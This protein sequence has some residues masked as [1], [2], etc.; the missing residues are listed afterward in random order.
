MAVEGIGNLVQ[1]LADHLFGQAP[2]A[3]A[4]TRIPGAPAATTS[5]ATEDTFTPSDQNLSILGAAQAA[6]IFQLSPGA[7]TAVAPGTLST[8]AAPN[9]EQVAPAQNESAPGPDAN[10]AP[11]PEA[12]AAP[13]RTDA[14]S[15][16]AAG[17]GPAGPAASAEMQNKI[18]QLN[19]SLPAL[20][21]TN[22]EIQEIDRIAS[23]IKDF[24]PAAYTDLV[25]QF[26]A[27]SQQSV[28]NPGSAS[29]GS[30]AISGSGT[31]EGNAPVFQPQPVVA[32]ATNSQSA[33]SGSPAGADQNP[34][35]NVN[36]NVPPAT[37]AQ[38]TQTAP[39]N[40]GGQ[41]GQAP[42]LSH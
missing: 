10:Q 36:V 20:G 31:A 5:T 22:N 12:A 3:Q 9:L 30:A 6:G 17:Q 7:V 41:N 40:A 37:Q 39:E 13:S 33:S 35:A 15:T 34:S 38:A 23:L 1:N 19:A 8:Q 42:Q 29:L 28:Q 21:L 25:N 27:R 24:N 14:N 2:A 16:A 4:G 32:P 18:Q 11:P 26:E